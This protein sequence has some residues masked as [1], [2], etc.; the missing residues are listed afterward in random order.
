LYSFH[1]DQDALTLS[2]RVVIVAGWFR[3]NIKRGTTPLSL[4]INDRLLA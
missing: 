3:A 4:S 1:I 2:A